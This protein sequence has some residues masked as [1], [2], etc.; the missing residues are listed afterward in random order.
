MRTFALVL[1]SAAALAAQEPPAPPPPSSALTVTVTGTTTAQ[2]AI[3]SK[4]NPS[5][6]PIPLQDEGLLDPA[7]FGEG[8]IFTKGDDI[9]QIY[10]KPGFTLKG[11]TLGVNTWE[12]KLLR[13][14]RD[15]KDLARAEGLM[16]S[17]PTV[18][19]AELR[20]SLANATK[21]LSLD[22]SD[23]AL[24]GRIVDANKPN[25]LSKLMFGAYGGQD[26]LDHVTFDFKI[27]E[28]KS[29]EVLLAVHH[30]I[31]RVNALG[32]LETKITRWCEAFAAIVA[33]KYEN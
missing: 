3:S 21:V 14:V 19:L 8:V 16:K 5:A 31:V 23:I 26:N 18:L 29:K 15:G 6:Q 12:T 30:R 9:D 25:G 2:A 32:K 11:R 10:V 20:K 28:T 33:L 17:I 4:Q 24:S 7:W 22:D 1:A 27:V 13:S